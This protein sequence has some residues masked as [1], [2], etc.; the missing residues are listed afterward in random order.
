M[1]GSPAANLILSRTGGAGAGRFLVAA[2]ARRAPIQRFS[3]AAARPFHSSVSR[4]AANPQSS[5]PASDSWQHTKQNI[6]EE[7]KSVKSSIESSIAGASGTGA[8]GDQAASKQD[9]GETSRSGAAEI[10][11]DAKSITGEMA[12]A[13]PRPALLWGGAGAIPYV[14]TAG[15]SIWLARQEHLVNLGY[16]KTMDSETASALLLHA[17]NIQVGFGAVLL[18]FLGAVHWGFEFSKYGGELGNRRYA[19]GVLPVVLAWPT[20]LL[21]PQMA[22]I[23]QWAS[24]VAMWFVDLRATNDGWVPKWYSTYRFWLTLAVGS[25]IIATLAGTNYYAPGSRSTMAAT[26]GKLQEEVQADGPTKMKLLQRSAKGNKGGII[27]HQEVGGDVEATSAGA[28][29]DSYVKI[30]NPKRQEEERKEKEEEERK[31]KEEQAKKKAEEDKQA[32]NKDKSGSGGGED[33]KDKGGDDGDKKDKK[34]QGG[35]DE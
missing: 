32:Q 30:G 19:V 7:V 2:A 27:K 14:T 3:P 24:F 18:S 6:K 17:Q 10:L 28:E 8:G 5:K 35:D 15:A 33:K 16:D 31:K 25:S 29:G 23:A 20:L 12:Q 22:L 4:L 26:A 11:K 21:A 13:V 9:A 1:L 34:D